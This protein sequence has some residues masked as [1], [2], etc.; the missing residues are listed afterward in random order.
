MTDH[1]VTFGALDRDTA[2]RFQPLRRQFGIT[3]FGMNLM[4]LQPGER[5]RIHAHEQQEEVYV[6]LEGELTLVIEGEEQPVLKSDDVAR[7]GHAVRRQVVNAGGERLVILALG[8]AGQHI[9]R[10]GKAW[11]SWDEEGDGRPPQEVPLPADL[12]T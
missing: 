6:V 12:P 7:V 8:S 11:E 10:D 2:E 9:G 5:G 1:D 4:L 3:G